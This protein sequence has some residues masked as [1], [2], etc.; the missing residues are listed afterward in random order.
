MTPEKQNRLSQRITSLKRKSS[1]TRKPSKKAHIEEP[2]PIVSILAA[3]TQKTTA[4]VPSPTLPN[5]DA[6][7]APLDQG[8]VIE[9]K[10][11]K[12]KVVRKKTRRTIENLG[13]KGS[14]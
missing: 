6:I 10:K 4:V 9:K 3:A 14:S 13:G 11:G 12:K 2:V 8:E 1:I 7:P 5:E